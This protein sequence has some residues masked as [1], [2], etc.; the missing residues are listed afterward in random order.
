[1]GLRIDSTIIT[2]R[3]EF[4]FFAKIKIS[5]C[6]KS[7]QVG[8]PRQGKQRG[9]GSK[10]KLSKTTWVDGWRRVWMASTPRLMKQQKIEKEVIFEWSAGI[11]AIHAA[12]LILQVSKNGGSD[13][14][15]EKS[16]PRIKVS[17]S[18]RQEDRGSRIEYPKPPSTNPTLL[19]GTKCD[20]RADPCHVIRKVYLKIFIVANKTALPLG[21]T[22]AHLPECSTLLYTHSGRPELYR[23]KGNIE[24][25][26]ADNCICTH[27]CCWH[28]GWLSWLGISLC[29]CPARQMIWRKVCG[30]NI[31]LGRP[32]RRVVGFVDVRWG[33]DIRWSSIQHLARSVCMQLQLTGYWCEEE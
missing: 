2:S 19:S 21:I 16:D 23:R 22:G 18:V 29:H 25:S 31:P 28:C 33:C 4:P 6:Q 26:P 11:A 32:F 1:M 20:Q 30:C 12:Q 27:H 8:F 10:Q 17:Q 13:D 15:G 7:D 24:S 9:N 14:D 3:C 5:K